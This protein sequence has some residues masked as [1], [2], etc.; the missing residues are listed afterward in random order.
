MLVTDFTASTSLPNEVALNWKQPLNFGSTTDEIIVTRTTT[1]YPMELYN[2]DFPNKATDSRGVEIFRGQ[3]IV[4]LDDSAVSV[5]GTTLTDT[6]ANFPT[7]PKLTGR[8]LRDSTSKVFRVLDNTSTSITLNGA[9]TAGKYVILVDFPTENR[10]LQNFEY[11]SESSP[12]TAGAGF[13]TNLQESVNSQLLLAEFQDDELANLIFVDGAGQKFIVKS[14]TKNTI[15]FFETSPIPLL[16]SGMA[17]LTSFSGTTAPRPYID[18]FLNDV[19][20]LNRSGTGLQNDTFYYYTSFV[21]PIGTNVAQANFSVVGSGAQTQSFAISAANNSFGSLLFDTYWPSLYR[22]LDST[23]DLEDLMQVFGFQ[24]NEIHSLIKTYKLQDAERVSASA[25]PA[26]SEQTGLPSIGYA[27]GADTLRRVAEN[28]IYCW[29]LKGSKEGLALFIRVITTWDVT[30]GDGDYGA[31]IEDFLP[32][33]QALRFFEESLGSTNTRLT[34][35]EPTFV[36]GARFVKTIPGVVIPGFF[37][38]REFVV[39][40]PNVALFIGPVESVTVGSNTTTITNSLA[41]FGANGSLKG[42]F[43]LPNQQEIN[44]IFE[45]IDNTSTSITV[46]GVFNNKD[47]GGTYAVLSPLNLSRFTVLNKLLPV[48]IPFGTR[49]GFR[50]T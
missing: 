22:E 15:N 16:A 45:I 17:I 3:L 19:E 46:R 24:L 13:V 27:L 43:L 36:S 7:I 40:V 32:N 39:T 8:L 29:K 47:I 6:T 14:N 10:A 33:V 48:Y 20:A 5:V 18:K 42:N 26:L 44:D 50:F 12:T 21:K 9:P 34:Q 35:T 49:A 1:H 28:L 2:T 41:T 23:G 37:T 38:F 11:S 31:A 25:L 30:G 4:G